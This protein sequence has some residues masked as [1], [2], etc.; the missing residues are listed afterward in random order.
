MFPFPSSSTN[1]TVFRDGSRLIP[2]YLAVMMAG[3]ETE[4]YTYAEAVQ[5]A[6]EGMLGQHVARVGDRL[7]NAHFSD[8]VRDDR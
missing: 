6:N 5:M 8:R 3:I 2:E 4:L 7:L 1:E